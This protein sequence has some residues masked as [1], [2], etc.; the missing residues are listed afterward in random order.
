MLFPSPLAKIKK[1]AV[2]RRL[3]HSSTEFISLAGWRTSMPQ[4]IPER[5]QAVVKG[6]LIGDVALKIHRPVNRTARRE[7]Q[8]MMLVEINGRADVERRAG[9][10]KIGLQGRLMKHL[11][12]NQHIGQNLFLQH[13]ADKAPIA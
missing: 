1:A 3:R 10:G 8:M 5:K 6:E 7:Q 11:R 4:M 13:G 2:A 12:A 9:V